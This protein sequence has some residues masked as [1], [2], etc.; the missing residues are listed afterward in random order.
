MVQSIPSFPPLFRELIRHRMHAQHCFISGCAA[1]GPCAVACAHGSETGFLVQSI[2]ISH[3]TLR[4]NLSIQWTPFGSKVIPDRPNQ[5]HAFD[6]AIGSRV[7]HFWRLGTHRLISRS[8]RHCN[9]RRTV[10]TF[11][12]AQ[13][14]GTRCNAS[15]F[16]WRNI[17]SGL[18]RFCPFIYRMPVPILNGIRP[19][20]P[21]WYRHT[22]FQ[23]GAV[24]EPSQL[25]LLSV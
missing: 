2:V 3:R 19:H 17:E 5:F 25:V 23:D 22:A 6:S 9:A 20:G 11:L 21:S 14:P 7:R 24:L 16:L 15:N 1:H 4:M 18:I 12:T 8:K 13:L 10:P